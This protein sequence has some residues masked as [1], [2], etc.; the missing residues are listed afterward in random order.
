MI[1]IILLSWANNYKGGNALL[2]NVLFPI[3]VLIQIKMTVN[4]VEKR[5]G[6]HVGGLLGQLQSPR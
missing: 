5:K 6:G 2:T 3:P 1:F 4:W